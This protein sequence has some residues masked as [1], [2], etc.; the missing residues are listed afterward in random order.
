MLICSQTDKEKSVLIKNAMF[1]KLLSSGEV[2][3]NAHMAEANKTSKAGQKVRFLNISAKASDKSFGIF[4]NLM[5]F[6]DGAEFSDYLRGKSS[7]Y[8]GVA[9]IAFIKEV[10]KYQ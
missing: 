9:S 2:D 6:Q 5:G 1:E 3:L 4:E 10:L 7:K 8:Y